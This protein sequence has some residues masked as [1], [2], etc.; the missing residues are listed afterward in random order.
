MEFIIHRVNL[1]E[2]LK[3]VPA[4]L[5]CEIDIRTDGSNL[6]LSHDPFSSGD[7]LTDY[8]D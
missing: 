1:I 2:E 3:T 5:G 7:K 4:E 6:I 8:L